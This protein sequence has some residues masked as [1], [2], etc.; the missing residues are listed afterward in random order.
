VFYKQIERKRDEWFDSPDCTVRGMVAYIEQR[1]QLRDAQ[2]SA[3]KTFLYLKLAHGNAPLW[4]LFNQ[5]RFNSDID[6]AAERSS[7]RAYT[8]LQQTPAAV[9]LLEYARLYDKQG[10]KLSN[11]LEDEILGHADEIDYEQ[12]FRDL[13]YGVTYPDYLYSLPMGAG[14]TFLMAAFIYLDLYL[15]MQ[16]PQNPLFAHNFMLFAPSGKKSSILPSLRSILSFDPTWVLPPDIAAKVHGIMHFEI[17]DEATSA[18]GSNIV[19][20][21]NAQKLW[22]HLSLCGDELMGLVAIT[23]AEKVILDR[24]DKTADSTLFEQDRE[25]Y[26]RIIQANELR[27]VIGQIPRMAVFVD[28]VHHVA[29]DTNRLRDVITGWSRAGSFAYMLG[30][31]GTPYLDTAEPVRIGQLLV[32]NTDLSNV[33]FHY[34]LTWAVDNFLKH[35]DIREATGSSEDIIRAGLTA[36][37][38]QYGS[39]TYANGTVAKAAIYCTCI[40][41]LEEEVYPLVATICAERGIPADEA[42]LRFHGGN[43]AYPASEEARHEFALLD[44]PQSRKRIILLVRIGQEG[45][46]CKSL[47]AVILSQKNACPTNLVLQTSCRCLR[48]VQRGAQEHALIWLNEWNY[49]KLDAE[50]KKTQNTSIDELIHSSGRHQQLMHRHSRMEHQRIHP[51]SF[52]QMHIVRTLQTEECEAQTAERLAREDIVVRRAETEVRER[53]LEAHILSTYTI[54]GKD[55]EPASLNRWLHQMVKESLGMTSIQQLRQHLSRLT[56]IFHAITTERDGQRYY[57][58]LIDQEAV[59]RNIRVAFATRRNYVSEVIMEPQE[60]KWLAITRQEL[61]QPF[62][63]NSPQDYYPDQHQVQ[64]TVTADKG[65]GEEPHADLEVLADT[66]ARIKSLGLFAAE[67]KAIIAKLREG[68]EHKERARQVKDRTYH[69]LPYHFDSPLERTF[70]VETAL[71]MR[72]LQEQG[73]EVYYNGDRA[74]T[75][76]KIECY[77]ET[78][79]GHWTYVGRYTP[80]FLLCQR[81]RN[82]NI[83]K[84]LIVETKGEGY[85]RNFRERNDFMRGRFLRD[86]PDFFD[87]LYLPERRQTEFAA[88]LRDKIRTFFNPTTH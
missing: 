2:L 19:R 73:I 57:S 30:F 26:S 11:E 78:S 83:C 59:R 43:K 65:D 41:Q 68:Q 80:D 49:R 86:N 42:V 8:F 55:T 64:A 23:N 67:E 50:F 36:F 51:F 21:P 62:I 52:M 37:L 72:E 14:K 47:T 20:N 44:T 84:I 82:G 3:I 74:V 69:Y 27:A 17:L 18:Q 13:F 85:E 15:A 5:G 76:F 56:Q 32:R 77:T 61:E 28:E 45:W 87:Y 6:L 4:Q 46:D 70:F 10:R 79:P 88:L 35:P 63:T 66:I 7:Q 39:L 40:E 34:P 31:S 53:D 81:G 71:P 48:Q 16:E 60:V 29:S 75:D 12:A 25:E 38:D 22:S 54:D 33:V 1:G 58:H 9:A 24:I